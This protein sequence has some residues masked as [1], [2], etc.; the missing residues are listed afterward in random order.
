MMIADRVSYLP[1]VGETGTA[2]ESLKIGKT[3]TNLRPP[4][5]TTLGRAQ[6]LRWWVMAW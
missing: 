6:R 4:R 5:W 2:F 1:D 3:C